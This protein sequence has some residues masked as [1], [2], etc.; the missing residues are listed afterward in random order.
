MK[1]LDITNNQL[2]DEGTWWL[3]SA[4]RSNTNLKR[5]KMEHNAVTPVGHAHLLTAIMDNSSLAAIIASNHSCWMSYGGSESGGAEIYEK[6]FDGPV[7]STSALHYAAGCYCYDIDGVS[8]ATP[9]NS[10]ARKILFAIR[11][12]V[13]RC[14]MYFVDLGLGV[15][16]RLLR[17]I[18][19]T[20]RSIQ[21]CHSKYW[22]PSPMYVDDRRV[23]SSVF[24]TMKCCFVPQ[25]GASGCRLSNMKRDE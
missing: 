25:I 3:A 12:D 11:E 16:P 15:L 7:C 8:Y 9:A 2:G 14:P 6:L 21:K 24:E 4:L 22:N 5:L 10:A 1:E 23:L 18:Q 19:L 17:L 13:Q 20:P